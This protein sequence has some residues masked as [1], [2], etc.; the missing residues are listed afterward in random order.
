QPD[1]EE[2]QRPTL[3]RRAPRQR[4]RA[5]AVP[6]LT[7]PMYKTTP[8]ADR[9]SG[10]GERTAEEAWVGG[11]YVGQLGAL[12]KLKSNP[13]AV[14]YLTEQERA[15]YEIRQGKGDDSHLFY[16]PQSD[17]AFDTTKMT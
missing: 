14:K 9:F 13:R 4:N 15:R 2:L 7:K 8:R 10:E 3:E 5:W 1:E 16:W 6:G 12:S 17:E 11:Q